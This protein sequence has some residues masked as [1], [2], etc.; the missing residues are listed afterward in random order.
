MAARPPRFIDAG[1]AH[2]RVVRAV[3]PRPVDRLRAGR[4]HHVARH[5][6]GR[7]AHRRDQVEVVAMAQQLRA[8]RREVLRDPVFRIAPRL[9]GRFDGAVG[10]EA[11]V[12]EADA[13][14]A[15]DEQVALAVLA[16]DV[17][18]VDAARDFQVDRVAPRPLDA[19]GPDGVDRPR[20]A[21]R[22]GRDVDEVAAVVLAQ[23]ERPDR[24]QR[25]FQGRADGRPVH[26]IRRMPDH[27]ARVREEA[28]EGHVI[29]LAV[30][31]DRRV[32]VVARDDR[33]DVRAVAAVG[34][35]LAFDAA[36]PAREGGRA[37]GGSGC[38]GLRGQDGE[39]CGAGAGQQ[40]FEGVAAGWVGQA[41]LQVL[42]VMI[43]VKI[44]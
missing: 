23:V 9:I 35:A 18:R 11:V 12:R 42:C 40:G 8:F 16:H 31:E 41:G 26:E 6:T 13:A 20:I 29:V 30:L 27:D 3:L 25:L 14:D 24:A 39:R 7:A 33:V 10:R 4:D 15:V 21:V 22:R 2:E 44:I 34:L 32:R 5:R 28:R 43:V 19:V 1:R 38:S 36:A 37:G 17:A